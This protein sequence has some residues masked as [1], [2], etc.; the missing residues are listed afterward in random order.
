MPPFP[1]EDNLFFLSSEAGCPSIRSKALSSESSPVAVREHRQ[2]ASTIED[3]ATG[4]LS[5]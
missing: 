2:F 1:L 5:R 3:K 4:E